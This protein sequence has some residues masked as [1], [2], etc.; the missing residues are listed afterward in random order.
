[1]V[2]NISVCTWQYSNITTDVELACL[3]DD[4]NLELLW[5]YSFDLIFSLRCILANNFFEFTGWYYK[6]I[7]E[8][9]KG[10]C[11]SPE[12]TDILMKD[13][14]DDVISKFQYADKLINHGRFKDDCCILLNGNPGENK[15]FFNIGNSCH[16][17]L[18]FN[19]D[20]S[21]TSVNFLDTT[22]YKGTRFSDN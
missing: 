9:V 12:I 10:T 16:K 17:Y 19:Y 3:A 14:T 20:I 11:P 15:K 13:I 21:H 8:A 18:R 7:I 6:Q 2:Y 1:M 22:I 4:S 5:P